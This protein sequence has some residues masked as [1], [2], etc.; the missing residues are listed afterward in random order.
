MSDRE[1]WVAKQKSTITVYFNCETE[2]QGYC[3]LLKRESR[4]EVQIGPQQKITMKYNKPIPES[5][6]VRYWEI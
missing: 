4:G 2:M 1:L 6:R 3:D 5:I